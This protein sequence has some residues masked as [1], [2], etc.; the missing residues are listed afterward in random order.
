[1]DS[2]DKWGGTG[3]GKF[4]NLDIDW[5]IG[6]DEAQNTRPES[7]VE[8]DNL[9]WTNGVNPCLLQ[10]KSKWKYSYKD[11]LTIK[12]KAKLPTSTIFGMTEDDEPF[13][14]SLEEMDA[15]AGCRDDRFR[16]IGSL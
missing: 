6:A 8:K 2:S 9:D 16:E 4:T 11:I 15:F 12:T 14:Y 1:M 5:N 3:S 10:D 7:Q 13:V